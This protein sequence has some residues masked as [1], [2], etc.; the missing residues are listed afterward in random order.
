MK[1][2]DRRLEISISR[3]GI[4]AARV[5]RTFRNASH[6][7]E[8]SI[9]RRS[10]SLRKMWR[11]ERQCLKP[12][13]SFCAH[14]NQRRFHLGL[15]DC[16]RKLSISQPPFETESHLV[17]INRHQIAFLRDKIYWQNVVLSADNHKIR[18]GAIRVIR[19]L[20]R[21]M[22]GVTEHFVIAF[23]FAFKLL[24]HWRVPARILNL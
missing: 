6:R 24:R 19:K 17:R 3:D 15:S 16:A 2:H 4:V 23:P 18:R 7:R 1:S 13:L 22:T 14:Q 10:P 21:H 9:A 11:A 8:T 5:P 12:S 20:D